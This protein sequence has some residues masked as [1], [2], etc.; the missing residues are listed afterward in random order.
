MA[1]YTTLTVISM[2]IFVIILISRRNP[3]SKTMMMVV[4]MGG[5][6]Y[7]GM[8]MEVFLRSLLLSMWV[9][10]FVGILL[11]VLA[12]REVLEHIVHGIMQSL[13][14]GMM[15]GMLSGMVS[16]QYWEMMVQIFSLK[17]FMLLLLTIFTFVEKEPIAKWIRSPIC[18]AG[19]II[20]FGIL[21]AQVSIPTD[22]PVS[23]HQHVT[24]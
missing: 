18:L 6:F 5:S 2:G 15:G 10:I 16:L 3:R 19:V 13:M 14:G 7:T 9:G 23:P 1:L 22:S 11:S 8:I 12:T 4:T 20:G 24:I 17:I 21:L